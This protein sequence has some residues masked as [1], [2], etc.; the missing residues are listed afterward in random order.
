MNISACIRDHE[1]AKS[2]WMIW[3]QSMTLLHQIDVVE[4]NWVEREQFPYKAGL[5]WGGH[6]WREYYYSGV[7][8]RHC[9]YHQRGRSSTT[10]VV[11]FK[12]SSR[13]LNWHGSTTTPGMT[14]LLLDEGEEWAGWLVLSMRQKKERCCSCS[15]NGKGTLFHFHSLLLLANFKD[16]PWAKKAFWGF[17]RYLDTHFVKMCAEKVHDSMGVWLEKCLIVQ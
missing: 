2:C 9:Y 3:A 15:K 16:S 12:Y 4:R 7:I 11:V 8:K 14:D 6:S 17:P 10:I 5:N 1:L 13:C